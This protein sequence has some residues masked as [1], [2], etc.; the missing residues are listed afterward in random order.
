LTNFNPEYFSKIQSDLDLLT[1]TFESIAQVPLT[2]TTDYS[3]S[4]RTFLSKTLPQSLVSTANMREEWLQK[5]LSG[6]SFTKEHAH[7]TLEAA[8]K[9][10]IDPDMD[11]SKKEDVARR[12]SQLHQSIAKADKGMRLI[13]KGSA[14]D[15]RRYILLTRAM[16][17]LKYAAECDLT[18]IERAAT[19]LF[20]ES[21]IPKS[22]TISLEFEIPLDD[23]KPEI[24]KQYIIVLSEE[25]KKPEAERSSYL[26]MANFYFFDRISEAQM[27]AKDLHLKHKEIFSD[28][29]IDRESKTISVTK[30]AFEKAQSLLYQ[31]FPGRT[32]AAYT[33]EQHAAVAELMQIILCGEELH[34]ENECCFRLIETEG[35][36]TPECETE[37]SERS[38]YALHLIEAAVKTEKQND[39][40]AVT[41][42]VH[43]F[44]KDCIDRLN[45]FA[46]GDYTQPLGVQDRPVFFLRAGQMY[47]EHL[48]ANPHDAELQAREMRDSDLL[49]ALT[50]L[51]LPFQEHGKET[52]IFPEEVLLD[53]IDPALEQYR[54]KLPAEPQANDQRLLAALIKYTR[55]EPFDNE[56]IDLVAGELN[57]SPAII[58]EAVERL[59]PSTNRGR[60]NQ[61]MG[62]V[63]HSRLS[64]D[65]IREISSKTGL[66][67]SEIEPIV[68]FKFFQMMGLMNQSVQSIFSMHTVTETLGD[69][70]HPLDP[71]Q[72]TNAPP[73]V[74]RNI[75]RFSPDFRSITYESQWQFMSS[76]KQ[77]QL[78]GRPPSLDGSVIAGQGSSRF[79]IPDVNTNIPARCT[80]LTEITFSWKAPAGYVSHLSGLINPT[81]LY[82]KFVDSLDNIRADKQIGSQAQLDE[83]LQMIRQAVSDY[84]QWSNAEQKGNVQAALQGSMFIDRLAELASASP[85]NRYR[86]PLLDQIDQAI[87]EVLKIEE[88]R[89]NRMI[90]PIELRPGRDMVSFD[91][92]C[93]LATTNHCQFLDPARAGELEMKIDEMLFVFTEWS[94][95]TPESEINAVEEKRAKIL[96]HF[97]D[98]Q[99]ALPTGQKAPTHI[100]KL[101]DKITDAI[102]KLSAPPELPG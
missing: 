75:F 98:L 25:L 79:T 94:N 84:T 31:H 41:S 74:I 91:Q 69:Y 35:R 96:V 66:P 9:I 17:N 14:K 37:I 93:R 33:P 52:S 90:E 45:G 89:F 50:S 99:K 85:N 32:A 72:Q 64:P 65:V 95:R 22:S 51:G 80:P 43:Q 1:S 48:M 36:S 29:T 2:G 71:E 10:L 42:S 16:V 13:Q 53:L 100:V 102:F 58:L 18:R 3:T 46:C 82:E 15:Q 87:E 92:A 5:T 6:L 24:L 27:M 57:L 21:A 78:E 55:N 19:S 49:K 38:S 28:I 39:R 47:T 20:P 61:L 40:R 54:P 62:A 81:P 60:F 23:L 83:T 7:Q 101:N 76:D 67:E 30:D 4:H 59:W 97:Q 70:Q 73:S 77:Q 11:L 88:E 86:G 26:D 8:M 44:C 68:R 56:T 12:I 34:P 63:V